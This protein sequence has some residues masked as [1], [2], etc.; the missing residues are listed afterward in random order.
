[1]VVS[2]PK[3]LSSEG[4][5]SKVLGVD[6]FMYLAQDVVDFILLDTF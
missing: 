5:S 1:S 3:G 4:S 6:P 2:C